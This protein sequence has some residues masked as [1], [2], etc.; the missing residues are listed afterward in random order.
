MLSHDSGNGA[1]VEGDA[2]LVH[3]DVDSPGRQSRLQEAMPAPGGHDL[4]K[5]AADIAKKVSPVPGPFSGP[6]FGSPVKVIIA[7]LSVSMK[8]VP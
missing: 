2:R 5:F 1:R 4:E 7:K 6:N 8:C 3:V